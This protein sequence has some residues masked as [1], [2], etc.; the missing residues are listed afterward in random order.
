MIVELLLATSSSVIFPNPIDYCRQNHISRF[1]CQ[2]VIDAMTR[3]IGDRIEILNQFT[4]VLI[5]MDEKRC[6][7]LR[8][9]YRS[10]GSSPT[11]CYDRDG[12]MIEQYRGD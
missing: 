2:I 5:R 12:I 1:D 9:D 10:L 11:Y 8:L 4:P 7:H 6:V 3:E